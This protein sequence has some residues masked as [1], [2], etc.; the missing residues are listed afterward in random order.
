MRSAFS[1]W[2]NFGG[3]VD[4]RFCKSGYGLEPLLRLGLTLFGIYADFGRKM[5]FLPFGVTWKKKV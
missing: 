4:A 5:Q 1:T 3:D 2:L